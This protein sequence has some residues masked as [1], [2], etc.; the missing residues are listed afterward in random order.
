M[1]LYRDPSSSPGRFISFF[2]CFILSVFFCF[3][4]FFSL[5]R[6]FFKEVVMNGLGLA[7]LVAMVLPEFVVESALSRNRRDSPTGITL[8]QWGVLIYKSFSY[9]NVTI[10]QPRVMN[11]RGRTSLI[12]SNFIIIRFARL[13]NFTFNFLVF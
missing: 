8:L 12:R 9:L 3:F 4:I 11:F 7:I 2:F 10:V 5:L 6:F 1:Y 13:K